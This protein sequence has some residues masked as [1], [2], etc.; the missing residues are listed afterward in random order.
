MNSYLACGSSLT[1]GVE[2][3]DFLQNPS[4]ERVTKVFGKI[5]NYRWPFL[6]FPST[7]SFQRSLVISKVCSS[8]QDQ[9]SA[10]Q[11]GRLFPGKPTAFAG[12]C[13]LAVSR[14]RFLQHGA[15]TAAACAAGPLSLFA[16]Q[17][18]TGGDHAHE[19]SQLPSSRG[20]WQDHANTL[21]HFGRETFLNAIGGD[22][23]VTLHSGQQPVWLTLMAVEDLPQQAAVN[24][25]SFAVRRKNAAAAPASNG[26]V[27]RFGSSADLPQGT[28]LFQHGS[29]G[30]FAL[31]TVPEGRSQGTFIAVVNQLGL[32]FSATRDNA[33]IPA[34]AINP[35]AATSSGTG[36]PLPARDETPA[37]RRAVTRD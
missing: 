26:F 3:T 1:F 9:A 37:V 27:L 13:H 20:T 11:N 4:Q 6:D 19:L 16:S 34:T 32:P 22:F 17:R 31:F 36:I 30:S 21:Q 15:L 5:Q 2:F 35:A 33:V 8:P 18:P 29:M 14:R 24:P 23:K 10:I 28:Y 7:I 25:A 12:R